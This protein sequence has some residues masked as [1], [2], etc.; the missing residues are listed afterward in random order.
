MKKSTIVILAVIAVIAVWAVT[1][2]NGLVKADEAVNTAWSNV[3]NQ[4]QRRADLIPNLV[5]TV[6][7]YAAHEKETLDAFACTA[8]VG[9]STGKN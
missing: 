2:Y 7:G 8:V 6:K 4:Y 3:E 1:G 5:N 9:C